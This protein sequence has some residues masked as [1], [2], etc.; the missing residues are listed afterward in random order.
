MEMLRENGFKVPAFWSVVHEEGD[1][2]EENP[3]PYEHT[4]AAFMWTETQKKEGARIF[5][6]RDIH[7]NVQCKK[8]MRWMQTI[9]TKYHLGHKTK[10]DG[11]KYFIKP[12]GIWQKL[13]DNFESDIWD[14]IALAGSMKAGC[15]LI[16]AFPKSI[17]DV[18]AIQGAT[19]KRKLSEIEYDCD[20]PFEAA[21]EEWNPRKQSLVIQGVAGCGKTN[22]ARNY[23]KGKG[24]EITELEDLKGVPENAE[25][26]IFDDQEYA[27]L[28]L[29]TQK[30]IADCTKSVRI[31]ARHT[32]GEKPHLP[33]IFTC[34][35]VTTCLDM[36]DTA[37]SRRCY[38]W[39]VD[40]EKIV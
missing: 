35:T 16:D 3:T 5:D 29:Q 26:L 23:F 22:W 32:N 40:W 36:S 33:A 4:H 39:N 11:K 12:I 30:M 14:A 17:S 20:K 28:K 24:Y 27:N 9:F 21:P 34:N 18:K 10:A 25:G 7:P 38:V 19:K 15:E 37:V 1:E 2:K 6:V 13:P 8:S 31:R